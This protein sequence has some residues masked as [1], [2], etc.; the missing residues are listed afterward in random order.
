[1]DSSVEVLADGQGWI[2]RICDAYGQHDVAFQREESASTYALGQRCALAFSLHQSRR[3]KMEFRVVNAKSSDEY[4][5]SATTPEAAA[6]LVLGEKV[7]R[8]G[9]QR[10]LRVKAYWQQRDQPTSMCRLYSMVA[11]RMGHAKN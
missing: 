1:M 8:S 7:V 9:A 5:V 4:R 6:Q 2:V 3:P 11:T 10:D